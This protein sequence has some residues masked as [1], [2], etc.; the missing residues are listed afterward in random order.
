VEKVKNTFASLIDDVLQVVDDK[1]QHPGDYEVVEQRV[2]ADRDNKVLGRQGDELITLL[3]QAAML[4]VKILT[5][6]DKQ[7]DVE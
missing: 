6:P 1:F 2:G 5:A 7:P 4:Y 3:E